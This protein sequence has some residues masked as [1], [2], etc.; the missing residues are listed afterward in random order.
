MVS[1]LPAKSVSMEPPTPAV[2]D[3]L[4][5][6]NRTKMTSAWK[7]VQDERRL[8]P[9]ALVTLDKLI[10]LHLDQLAVESQYRKEWLQ[11][12]LKYYN[13][14]GPYYSKRLDMLQEDVVK[15]A[16]PTSVASGSPAQSAALSIPDF[17][18]TA[19]NHHSV[20]SATIG[21]HDEPILK[22]VEDISYEWENGEEQLGFS[23]TFK[24]AENPFFT[25]REL[26]KKFGLEQDPGTFESILT[27]SVGSKIDWKPGKDVTIKSVTKRQKNKR[28]G[29]IRMVKKN[30][31]RVSFFHF[32]DSHEIPSDSVLDAMDDRDVRGLENIL[33]LE[34]EVG[35]ILR[36]KIISHAV[37]W[38]LGVEVDEDE[39]SCS[40]CETESLQESDD[41]DELLE[42]DENEDGTN[43]D[44]DGS[45]D[46][47]KI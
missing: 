27:R 9:E 28:T 26:T 42:D 8:S 7:E 40:S 13:M 20:V 16:N 14:L 5:S 1:E 43:A 39:E 30:V 17:W 29:E 31:E 11:L 36:D 38:Y 32:F 10:K 44:R 25:N 21:T 12:K 2:D 4:L 47:T 18:L 22:Y 46:A 37:G 45:V 34:Y 6:L 33:E 41:S 24:F 35:C 23:I 15:T 19:M 3:S